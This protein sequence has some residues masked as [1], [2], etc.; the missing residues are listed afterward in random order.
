MG[1]DAFGRKI[2]ALAKKVGAISKRLASVFDVVDEVDALAN[3]LSHPNT[4]GRMG[5]GL[6]GAHHVDD[7]MDG[8]VASIA[9]ERGAEPVIGPRGRRRQSMWERKTARPPRVLTDERE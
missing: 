9:E 8:L 4:V 3:K 7:T 2:V 1:Q 6:I 5:D